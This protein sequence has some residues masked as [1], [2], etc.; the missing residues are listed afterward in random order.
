MKLW[1]EEIEEFYNFIAAGG[2]EDLFPWEQ[3]PRLPDWEVWN[4]RQTEQRGPRAR[5]F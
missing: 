5:D 3:G 2:E 1:E 4:Y